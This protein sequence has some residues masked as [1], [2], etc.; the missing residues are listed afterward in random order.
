MP[1]MNHS[2]QPHI[3]K[4]HIKDC[5]PTD[6]Y[7]WWITKTPEERISAVEI[8]RRQMYG[9]TSRLQRVIKISSFKN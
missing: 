1:Y 3:I 4:K 5:K 9:N 6:N 2:I 7:N 8:L